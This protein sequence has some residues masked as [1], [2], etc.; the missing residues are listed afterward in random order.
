MTNLKH[1]MP[2]YWIALTSWTMTRPNCGGSPSCSISFSSVVLLQ[3]ELQKSLLCVSMGAGGSAQGGT[4]T[5]AVHSGA[6]ACP[7]GATMTRQ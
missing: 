3:P 2:E 1:R 5:E 7:T 4:A 6:E